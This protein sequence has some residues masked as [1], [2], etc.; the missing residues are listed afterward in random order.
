[1][2]LHSSELLGDSRNVRLLQL[3]S[4]NPRTS[5]SELARQV[6]MS[7][8][9]VRERV[10]RLE[11]AGVIQGYQLQIDP[12]ALG[13][14]LAAFIRVRPTSG[15]LPKIIALARQMPEVTECYRVT[16]EDCF[17]LKVH[18]NELAHLDRILDQLLVFGQTTTSL[19]QSVPVPRR[20]LPLPDVS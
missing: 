13:Y 20:P 18:L 16:G 17:V 2:N 5:I 10:E 14:P 4:E 1:M 15:A 9:A 8:P 7:A 6:G 12:C 3:L 19:I 11:E